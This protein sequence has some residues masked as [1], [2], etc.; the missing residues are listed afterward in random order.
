MG[1]TRI[2]AAACAALALAGPAAADL[3][4]LEEVEVI[5]EGLIAA[6]I[7]HE[8]GDE[9]PTIRTRLLR[10][11]NF[12]QGLRDYARDLGYS[13]EQIKAFENNSAHKSALIDIAY[14]RMEARGLDRDDPE[15]WCRIGREEMAAGTQ[16]GQLLR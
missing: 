3:P 16:V 7:A 11:V 1:P 9:C 10:G 15:S 13:R 4:Q 8:I 14:A 12:L 6:G 2:L 5:N